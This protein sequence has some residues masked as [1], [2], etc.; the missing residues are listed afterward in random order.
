MIAISWTQTANATLQRI[1]KSKGLGRFTPRNTMAAMGFYLRI[2]GKILVCNSTL[3][4]L[5]IETG[6]NSATVGGLYK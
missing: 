6:Y 4:A 1:V 5:N 2:L 3:Y